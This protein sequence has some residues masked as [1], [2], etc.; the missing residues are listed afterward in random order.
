MRRAAKVDANQP[1]IVARFRSWGASVQPLH[2]VGGGVPDLLVGICGLNV[3]CEVKDGDKPPSRRELNGLQ[4]QWLLRWQGMEVH[5]VE[6]V[7]DVDRMCEA[8]RQSHARSYQEAT[9][10]P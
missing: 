5:V 3:L 8:I 4:Q 6:T 9:R 1:E 2:T 10:R 7:D